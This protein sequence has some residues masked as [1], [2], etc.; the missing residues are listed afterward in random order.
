MHTLGGC[1]EHSCV[2]DK[3]KRGSNFVMWCIH[4][5]PIPQKCQ[6][7]CENAYFTIYALYICF[8]FAR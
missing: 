5:R 6:P 4:I 7:L 2:H 8:W 3:G 1:S